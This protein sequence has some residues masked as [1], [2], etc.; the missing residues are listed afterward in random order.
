MGEKLRVIN[1]ILGTVEL[2]TAE[3]FIHKYGF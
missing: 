2:L 3:E 1:N